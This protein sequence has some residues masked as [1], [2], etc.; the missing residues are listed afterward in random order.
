MNEVEEKNPVHW[1]LGEDNEERDSFPSQEDNYEVIQQHNGTTSSSNNLNG[2]SG[3][4]MSVSAQ[5]LLK[6]KRK[7]LK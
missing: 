6:E 2:I 3:I 7:R 5:Q 1:T 4:G